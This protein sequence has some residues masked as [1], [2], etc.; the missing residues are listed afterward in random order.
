MNRREKALER[1]KKLREMERGGT[2]QEALTAAALISDIMTKYQLEPEDITYN[3]IDRTWVPLERATYSHPVT[4]C[5]KAIARFTSTRTWLQKRDGEAYLVF[6]GETHDRLVADYLTRVIMRALRNEAKAFKK[7]NAYRFSNSKTVATRTFQRA[8]SIR[9]G[10]RLQEMWK[11][12]QPAPHEGTPGLVKVK[13]ALI[14]QY[15]K[16]LGIRI[17]KSSHSQHRHDP[18][19]HASGRQAGDRV[20]LHKGVSSSGRGPLALKG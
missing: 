19:A 4:H 11:A 5:A 9:I 6:V 20:G 2:E 13:D 14:A 15:V 7:T 18:H 8:M 12:A 17:K 10:E 3:D 16:A 1:I